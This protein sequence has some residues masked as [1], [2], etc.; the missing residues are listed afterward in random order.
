[1]ET[2]T[3][4]YGQRSLT[5]LSLV[6]PIVYSSV[7]ERLRVWLELHRRVM[8]A[9]TDGLL[10]LALLSFSAGAYSSIDRW[11]ANNQLQTNAHQAV[12]AANHRAATNH[13]QPQALVTGSAPSTTPV[14]A[15]AVA[16]YNVAPKMPRYLTIQKLGVHARVLQVGLTPD[17]AV[18]TPSSSFDA[19]WFSGSA[20]PGQPGAALIDGHRLSWQAP[21]IFYRLADL[22]PGDNLQ[23][24]MGDG[25]L[26][27]FHV[28]TTRTY[29]ANNTDMSQLL[30]P[31][32]PSQPG[33]NLISCYGR[34]VPG[35]SEFDTRIAVFAS[36]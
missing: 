27:N 22:Q 6:V 11:R 34:I 24:E 17:G 19:A 35:T 33:L 7:I 15:L 32:N 12:S 30:T 4:G 29:P 14:P 31:I 26:I 21:G 28:V 2:A 13:N 18:G 20:L 10:V 1:M 9:V 23:V 36:Q 16:A 25:R 5:Y 3:W 8:T